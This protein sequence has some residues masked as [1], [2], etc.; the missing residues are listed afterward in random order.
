MRWCLQASLV[1]AFDLLAL[2]FFFLQRLL[3]SRL[4]RPKSRL[5]TFGHSSTSPVERVASQLAGKR[6]YLSVRNTLCILSPV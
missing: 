1:F 6:Q 2:P 4:I 5:C 3:L